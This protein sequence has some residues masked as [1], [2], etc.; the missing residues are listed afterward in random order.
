[1]H[2]V[3]TILESVMRDHARLVSEIRLDD[4]AAMG[5]EIA[6]RVVHGRKIM[7][8]GCGGSAADSQHFAAEMIGRF[9]LER[10]PLPCMALTADTSVMTAIGND[11]GFDQI[12]ARQV[13]GHGLRGDVLIAIS[14]SGNSSVVQNAMAQANHDGIRVFGLT[15]TR[16]PER[17]LSMCDRRVTVGSSVTARIQE[18]H[19][20]IL[21]MLCETV[22]AELGVGR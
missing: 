3:M 14:T 9:R 1:M 13:R 5:H 10:N 2:S 18:I 19:E 7:I 17:F 8:C 12:F 6:E 20:L 16:A 15:S 22:D 11:Y 21:H 4:V